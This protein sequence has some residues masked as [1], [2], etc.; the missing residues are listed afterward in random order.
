MDIKAFLF[1][2]PYVLIGMLSI[3]IIT[4][5]IILCIVVLNKLT[6]PRKKDDS[7]T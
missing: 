6:S 2:L 1:T 5:I 3:F 4:L 7:D